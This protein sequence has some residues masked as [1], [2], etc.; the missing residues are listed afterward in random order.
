M[1]QKVLPILLCSLPKK[2]GTAGPTAK[3]ILTD[4][5]AVVVTHPTSKPGQHCFTPENNVKSPIHFTTTISPIIII[6]TIPTSKA[7]GMAHLCVPQNQK[8]CRRLCSWHPSMWYS[9]ERGS[10]QHNHHIERGSS[11]RNHHIK[12]RRRRTSNATDT[13]RSTFQFLPTVFICCYK[14]QDPTSDR[15][16][17]VVDSSGGRLVADH[18]LLLHPLPWWPHLLRRCHHRCRW[19]QV[20]ARSGYSVSCLEVQRSRLPW[21]QRGELVH[22]YIYTCTYGVNVCAYLHTKTHM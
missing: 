7:A 9:R 1:K 5:P 16:Q 12:R 18:L 19:Q 8:V 22:T 17:F 6:V 14:T 21:I 10:S 4:T 13:N 15:G 2:L 20:R 11:Q 3:Q